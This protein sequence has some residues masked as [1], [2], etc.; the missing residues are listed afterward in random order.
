LVENSCGI[1]SSFDDISTQSSGE[2]QVGVA[3]DEDFEVEEITDSWVVQYEY[4][5]D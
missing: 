4:P 1:S 5:L 3:L 2:H